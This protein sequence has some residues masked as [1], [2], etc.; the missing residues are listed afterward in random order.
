MGEGPNTSWEWTL[1][2]V[3]RAFPGWTMEYA[4]RVLVKEC[5]RGWPLKKIMLMEDFARKF[6]E[7]CAA[8]V[9][10]SGMNIPTDP[11]AKRVMVISARAHQRALK[12]HKEQ[13]DGGRKT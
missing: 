12:R 8:Q 7:I 11:F 13:R 4:E 5:E 6:E 2:C 3:L 1:G 10:K 9:P